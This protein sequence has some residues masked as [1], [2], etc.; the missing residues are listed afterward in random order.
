[1]DL[2]QVKNGAVFG[3]IVYPCGTVYRKLIRK[4]AYVRTYVV[5][6][7]SENSYVNGTPPLGVHRPAQAAFSR[8]PAERPRIG[9]HRMFSADPYCVL[10]QAKTNTWVRTPRRLTLGTLVALTPLRTERTM[11]E[12]MRGFLSIL[13]GEGVQRMP[14]DYTRREA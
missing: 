12:S 6:A 9:R 4:G 3:P 11:T 1:M 13:R 8:Y 14:G 10:S 2:P 5:C 7:C